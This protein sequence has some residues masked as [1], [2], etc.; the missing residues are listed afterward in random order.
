ML[1]VRRVGL[2]AVALLFVL[3]A[4]LF[5]YNNP[6]PIVVDTGFARF[7]NV[8]LSAALAIAFAT[9]WLFGLLCAGIALL[10]MAGE[11]RRLRRDLRFAEAE[12]SSLRNLPLQDAD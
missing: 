12:I 8:S 2:V 4:A 10:R 1:T 7:E 11:R 6:D 9:G 5:A 3:I